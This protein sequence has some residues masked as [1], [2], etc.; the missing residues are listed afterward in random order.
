MITKKPC[1]FCGVS[2]RS[3]EIESSPGDVYH[4]RCAACGA[5]GPRLYID[6]FKNKN[7]PELYETGSKTLAAFAWNKRSG[8]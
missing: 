1:P 5:S 6:L 8:F 7:E 4:V 2:G 3:L